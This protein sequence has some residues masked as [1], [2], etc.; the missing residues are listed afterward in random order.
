MSESVRGCG[1]RKIG[2]LYLVSNAGFIVTCDGLPLKLD[3]CL[4]CGFAPPFSRNL[5]RLHPQYIM[6]A[7]EE[8]HHKIVN[9]E[10]VKIEC[11]C[12][13]DCPVCHTKHDQVYGLMFVGTDYTPSSF[14]RE[15]V[16]MGVSK[17]IP[18]IPTW[19][20]LGETWVLLAHK[21]V[22]KV[23]LETLKENGLYVKEP[24]T[25]NAIFYAFKPQRIEMP[26]WAGSLTDYEVKLLTEHGITPVFLDPTPENRKRHKN[27]KVKIDVLLDRYMKEVTDEK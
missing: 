10:W 22:P 23:D 17:R 12:L 16:K 8:K 6:Q 27:A 14:I 9:S 5:Q 4:C 3:T 2:G 20:K 7:S 18:Q 11:D 21:H 25:E 13:L 1:Y 15:A 24:E 26:V 19:L